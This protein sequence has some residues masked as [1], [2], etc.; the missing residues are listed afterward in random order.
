MT[1][2]IF[3][4]KNVYHREIEDNLKNEDE[5]K[6]EYELKN[7][8]ACQTKKM[9]EATFHSAIKTACQIKKIIWHQTKIL[10]R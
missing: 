5:L 8:G 1:A 10:I 2:L 9:P 3:I 6:T 7:E 4:K